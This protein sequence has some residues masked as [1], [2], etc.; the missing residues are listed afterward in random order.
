MYAASPNSRQFGTQRTV[1]LHA[2]FQVCTQA[3]VQLYGLAPPLDISRADV[4]VTA[5]YSPA[6]PPVSLYCNPSTGQYRLDNATPPS[7]YPRPGFALWQSSKLTNSGFA[8]LWYL[9]PSLVGPT[10]RH[11]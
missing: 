9:L 7:N 5:A 10:T 3:S 6:G 4:N 8:L 2:H 1:L 11:G